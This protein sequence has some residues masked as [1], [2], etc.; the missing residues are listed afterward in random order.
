MKNTAQILLTM[1]EDGALDAQFAGPGV[2][3]ITL[4]GMLE[5]AKP[6][7]LD[8]EG[9]SGEARPALLLANGALPNGR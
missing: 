5:L 7:I 9:H 4:L 2:N 6:L 1:T 3:K 8:P